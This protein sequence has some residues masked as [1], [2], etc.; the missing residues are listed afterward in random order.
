MVIVWSDGESVISHPAMCRCGF[1]KLDYSRGE[2]VK[3]EVGWITRLKSERWVSSATPAYNH[4]GNWRPFPNHKN[5]KY[6]YIKK[7]NILLVVRAED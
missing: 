6:S 1:C 7:Y 2:S 5:G 3:Y 4:K